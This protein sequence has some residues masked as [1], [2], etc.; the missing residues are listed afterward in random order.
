MF[1]KNELLFGNQK[2]GKMYLLSN[3]RREQLSPVENYSL[4]VAE[5]NTASNYSREAC[6]I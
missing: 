5:K 1:N 2:S 3:K 6:N 4:L